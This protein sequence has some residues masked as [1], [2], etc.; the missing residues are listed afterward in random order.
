MRYNSYTSRKL[1]AG[2][3]RL[4]GVSIMAFGGALSIFIGITNPKLSSLSIILIIL[5]T[6][7]GGVFLMVGNYKENEVEWDLEQSGQRVYHRRTKF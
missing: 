5:S 6:L 7:F 1:K 3:T 2:A 4:L